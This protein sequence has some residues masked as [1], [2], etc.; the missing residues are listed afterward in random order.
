MTDFGNKSTAIRRMEHNRNAKRLFIE[1]QNGRGYI[2]DGVTRYRRDKVA[3]GA[4]ND[5]IGQTYHTYLRD[6]FPV[7]R[8]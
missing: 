4:V 7:T 2:M 3:T 8:V 1:F 5:S 6:A